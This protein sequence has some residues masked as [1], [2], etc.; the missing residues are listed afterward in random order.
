M[1]LLG[2]VPEIVLWY[3]LTMVF[4]AVLRQ[5]PYKLS[6]TGQELGSSMLFSSRIGFSGTPSS[7][8]PEDLGTCL[9]EAENEGIRV[10][11]SGFT[12]C[13]LGG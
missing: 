10:P 8:L 5:Q 4:D 3:L 2:P 7:L 11:G 6:A 12:V 1:E 13:R 9:F